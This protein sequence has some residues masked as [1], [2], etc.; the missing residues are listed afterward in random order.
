MQVAAAWMSTVFAVRRDAEDGLPAQVKADGMRMCH[1]FGL[2]PEKTLDTAVQLSQAGALQACSAHYQ[3][4]N[5]SFA[6]V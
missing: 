5:S 6:L 2:W 1:T 4:V 3:A